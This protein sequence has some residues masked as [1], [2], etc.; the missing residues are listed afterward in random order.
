MPLHMVE[1]LSELCTSYDGFIVDLWGVIHDGVETYPGV[2]HAL[3]MLKDHQKMIIFVS[4]APRRKAR[5]VEKLH[6]LGIDDK[7]YFSL[8]TSGE[9]AYDAIKQGLPYAKAG[10][11]FYYIGPDRDRGLLV[12]L[13]CIETDDPSRATFALV[14]GYD[15]DLSHEHEKQKDLIA[16]K[17]YNLPLICV[18]PDLVIVRIDGSPALCAGVIARHYEDMGGTVHYFGKPHAL[19]YQQALDIFYRSE[20]KRIA[21][22]GDNIET[23]ILG[24]KQFGI[25][26]YLIPGG[27]MARALNI[28]HGELP[29]PVQLEQVCSHY[30]VKPTGALAAFVW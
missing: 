22:I 29:N 11:H 7:E 3:T 21:A 14:T 2:H 15:H 27:I 9:T 13:D 19:I 23:D 6:H 30:N 4:N 16:I 18:N 20:C 17:A 26:S 10:D 24:A 28:A 5:A 12:D 25:D 1:T 8:I